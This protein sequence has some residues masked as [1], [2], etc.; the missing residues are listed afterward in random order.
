MKRKTLLLILTCAVFGSLA[1]AFAAADEDDPLASLSY[2]TG[3]F[4]DQVMGE[5]DKRLDRSDE[6]LAEQISAD[7]S[8]LVGTAAT[9]TEWCMKEGDA[10]L[11]R[12]GT[13]ILPLAGSVTVH[14]DSGAVVDV[15]TAEVIPSGGTLSLRHRYLA[16]ED[17]AAVFAA[18]SP[19]AVVNYQGPY[20]IRL[21]DT[22]DHYAMARALREMHM[23]R[24]NNTG[25]GDG[26]DLESSTTRIQ[27]LIMFIRVLGEEEQALAWDGSMPFGDVADWARPYV[28]YA[29]EMG[30]T[31]GTGPAQFSPDMAATASQYTEFVL[32]A[33]GYSSTA[34]T[35]LSDTLL[36]AREAGVLTRG[37]VETL[38]TIPA[39]LRAHLVYISYYA[40]QAELPDG[41]TLTKR[42]QNQGVFT[43]AEWKS[44]CALVTTERL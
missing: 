18:A 17:T 21:S 38:D 5:V 41:T 3:A 37:E 25:Y 36:R 7:G 11:G 14:Y 6:A 22:P 23:F 27:A 16:A 19:T 10:L 34:N 39:F 15:I 12:I 9:W 40:L 26:F 43:A 42:L 33:M 31:N 29:Y 4:T 28:G 20:D 32:R 2:L 24:G 44:A 8:A 35:D 1:W 30:Y 13:G